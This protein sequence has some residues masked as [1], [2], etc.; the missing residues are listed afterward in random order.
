MET[1]RLVMRRWRE[2]DL[3]PFAELSA[4]PEVMRAALAYGFGP[5][6]RREIVSMTA[7]GNLRSRAVMERL[8][9]RRDAADDFDHPN[10]PAGIPP[11]RHVLYRIGRDS[12]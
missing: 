1:E 11:R 6:G 10:V 3:E 12:F 7:A 5:A 4:D 2:A 9:M 8:G